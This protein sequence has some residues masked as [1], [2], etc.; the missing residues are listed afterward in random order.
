[1]ISSFYVNYLLRFAP[2]GRENAIDA[3]TAASDFRLAQ[4]SILRSNSALEKLFGKWDG[5]AHSH[6]NFDDTYLIAFES[7]KASASAVNNITATYNN[8]VLDM[9]RIVMHSMGVKEQMEFLASLFYTR[10]GTCVGLLSGSDSFAQ[11][12]WVSHSADCSH[13]PIGDVGFN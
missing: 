6:V 10:V 1:V 2:Y 7:E 3:D 11:N 9:S 13:Y 8:T 12:H 4:Q 5:S